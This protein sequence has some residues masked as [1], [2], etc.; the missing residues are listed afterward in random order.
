[1]VTAGKKQ[2]MLE[3][4]LTSRRL[5]EREL[6]LHGTEEAPPYWTH[7]GI[8]QEGVGVGAPFAVEDHDYIMTSH[9]TWGAKLLRLP[10]KKVLAGMYGTKSGPSSGRISK[11]GDV[12]AGLLQY[13]GMI[14]QE[15]NLSVGVALAS[16]VNNRDDVT[17]AFFGDGATNR[18]EF[19]TALNFATVKQAPIVFFIE[20]NE[21]VAK[22]P[23]EKLTEVDDLV[24][25]AGHGLPRNV[26]DG[27]DI[28]EV[29]DATKEAVERARSGG[30]PTIIEAKTSRF[31]P[32][33]EGTEETRSQEEIERLK[34]RD[35][36]DMYRS[37]L[38][39]EGVVTQAELEE[40]EAEI[41]DKLDEAFEFVKQDPQPDIESMYRVYADGNITKDGL[42]SHEVN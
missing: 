26:I 13:T 10:L 31:R 11:I 35:P 3:V 15:I 7:S 42:V 37:K 12:D 16:K 28:L 27:Q 22:S 9:R 30:G 23:L 38:L 25:L 20:N 33:N 18:G 6:E 39:E 1:M 14:G 2:R 41:Q 5:A 8:G 24:E 40:L 17:L 21:M 19:H 34:E 29:H 36:V 4:M 32:H